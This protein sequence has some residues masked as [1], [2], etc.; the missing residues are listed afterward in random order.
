MRIRWNYQS[1]YSFIQLVSLRLQWLL[2]LMTSFALLWVTGCTQI[3]KSS[4]E[5]EIISP[6]P[7]TQAV[8]KPKNTQPEINIPSILPMADQS[9]LPA[10]I[11]SLLLQADTEYSKHNPQGALATLERALRINPRYAEIWSRMAQ[12]YFEQG[13]LEQARQHAKR[14][15]SVIKNNPR[16]NEFNRHIIDL[17]TSAD[18]AEN[19]KINTPVKF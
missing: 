16:F 15:N 13:D 6:E 10:A 11:R 9:N 3:Q 2:L 4:T 5:L 14:S 1:N 17:S 12:I 19:T 7:P 18:S 8:K